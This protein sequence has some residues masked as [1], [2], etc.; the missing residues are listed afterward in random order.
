[1]QFQGATIKHRPNLFFTGLSKRYARKYRTTATSSS[2]NKI[3]DNDHWRAAAIK[4]KL[5]ID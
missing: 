2:D 4:S 1:M 5:I 3:L